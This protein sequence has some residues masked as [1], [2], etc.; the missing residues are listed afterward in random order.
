MFQ[1]DLMIES[2]GILGL[3]QSLWWLL[4]TQKIKQETFPEKEVID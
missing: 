2:G 3:F 1:T 4:K